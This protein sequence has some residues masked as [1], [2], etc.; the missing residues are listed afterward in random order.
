MPESPQTNGSS[1]PRSGKIAA[2]L[3]FVASCGATYWFSQP[4]GNEDS[5][6]LPLV[7]EET[8]LDF[9]E[10]WETKTFPWKVKIQNVSASPVGIKRFLSTCACALIKP[11]SLVIPPGG[12]G[13]IELILDLSE[14]F[15]KDRIDL[16]ESKR[17]FEVWLSPI[18]DGAGSLPS[19]THWLVKGEVKRALSVKP[20]QVSFETTGA[21]NANNPVAR[22]DVRSRIGLQ[23]L[24]VDTTPAYL[25]TAI[26][27]PCDDY[28]KAFQI[29]LYLK[30]PFKHGAAR[31]TIKLTP[32]SNVH[33]NIPAMEIPIDGAILGDIQIVPATIFLG[34]AKVGDTL[35]ETV[36]ARSRSAQPFEF[37]KP[38]DS[39]GTVIIP[40]AT[41]RPAEL[42]LK[43]RRFVS[44][45]GVQTERLTM[46]FV[47]T[48]REN[49]ETS[50][51]ILS[52]H[53]VPD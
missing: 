8:D 21:F 1:V 32:I 38:K 35:E 51:L 19:N 39:P 3:F 45:S 44:K 53:G 30:E 9:G 31:G 29:L 28:G 42:G 23:G 33:M 50:E 14:A 17:A 40:F 16:P 48:G 11:E 27:N 12:E 25:F 43:L 47:G 7:V 49:H 26:T 15:W 4:A 5:G 6:K 36:I 24:N 18:V 22:I 10:V 37:A 20:H 52:Y 13:Q 34:T 41:G 2:V 46:T